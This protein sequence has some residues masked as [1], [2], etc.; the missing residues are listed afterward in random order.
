MI[1]NHL[2]KAVWDY[3][4][5]DNPESLCPICDGSLVGKRYVKRAVWHWPH[6][7]KHRADCPHYESHWHLIAKI[8]QSRLPGWV[9]EHP[10][11]TTTKK[12]RVDA[13]NTKHSRIREF[14]HTVNPYY[15]Q[16]HLVL[17]KERY[18][19]VNWVFDGDLYVSLR[20]RPAKEG[21][22]NFLTPRAWELFEKIGGLVHYE[23]LLWK[24]WQKNIWFPY[25][26]DDAKRFLD[27]FATVERELETG[28][29]TEIHAAAKRG[30]TTDGS[31]CELG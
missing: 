11:Q 31:A 21:K 2:G 10:I 24:H 6:K 9:I 14:V 22:K 27:S 5:T 16:K 30:L 15:Y 29:L 7:P 28:S 4:Y 19:Q 25:E 3:H 8:A 17:R 12:Y 20:S 1:H 26:H 18:S 13:Y 23:G